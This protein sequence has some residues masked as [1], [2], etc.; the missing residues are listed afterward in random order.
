MPSTRDIAFIGCR[1]LALYFLFLALQSI[2]Y[3]LVSALGTLATGQ[4]QDML[5]LFY[6]RSAW[7]LL[8]TPILS[9]GMVVLLWFGAGRLSREV[10]EAP[11]SEVSSTW[12]PQSLLS[13]GVVLLGLI[14]VTLSLPSIVLNLLFIIDGA[15]EAATF[16]FN[17]L[18]S[19]VVQ[20]LIGVGLILGSKGIAEAIARLRRW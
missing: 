14:V 6:A 7:L 4:Q 10:A 1:L 20:C 13:V 8:A 18:L 16:Q 3:S 2:P 19:A 17:S 11:P 5:Q 15:A 12:S 9:L